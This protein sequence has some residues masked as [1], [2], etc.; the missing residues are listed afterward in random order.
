MF[1][2]GQTLHIVLSSFLLCS[3]EQVQ[4]ENFKNIRKLKK[5]I[6]KINL[7][8]IVAALLFFYRHNVY[9]DNYMYSMFS[10]CEY[11]VILTNIWFHALSVDEFKSYQLELTESVKKE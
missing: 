10:L 5:I 11:I 2:T 7:I 9:C 6:A 1:L 3:T 4:D 8:S